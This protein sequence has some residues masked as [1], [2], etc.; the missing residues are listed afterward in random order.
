[1]C[2]V[3]FKYVFYLCPAP[4]IYGLIRI[5]HYEQIP[6][7]S[8]EN[9]CQRILTVAHILKFIHHDIHHPL[10]P[11]D[12][13]RFICLKY[14]QCDRYEIV[15]V[16]PIHLLLL[17]QISQKY[18]ILH[19]L[20]LLIVRKK[21][22][23]P[24]LCKIRYMQHLTFHGCYMISRRV[25]CICSRLYMC[26]LIHSLEYLL[27]IFVIH[28]HKV[29]WEVDRMYVFPQQL[30]TESMK[31]TDIASITV[32]YHLSYPLAHLP[33]CLVRKCDTQYIRS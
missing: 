6:V 30:H 1:M 23:V 33:G 20:S 32:T 8:T 17:I 7:I 24:Y 29:L 2:L 9:L 31:C 10:L 14:I 28:D 27:C 16:K 15:I 3:K 26:I 5:S 21:F 13:L 4:C 19:L 12:P 18:L 22:F 25:K 11:F